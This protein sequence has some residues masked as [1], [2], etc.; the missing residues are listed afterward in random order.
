MAAPLPGQNSKLGQ[1]QVLMDVLPSPE[2]L[3]AAWLELVCHQG[4]YTTQL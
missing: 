3:A 1:V 4:C 2:L